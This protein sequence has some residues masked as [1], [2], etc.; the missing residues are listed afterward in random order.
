MSLV[1]RL[2]A[3]ADAFE[4]AYASD[5]WSKLDPYFTADAVYETVADAPFA[6]RAEGRDAVKAYFKEMVDNFDRRFASRRVDVIEGPTEQSG[7]VW[8][9]WAATYTLQDA[10]P[11][12]MEGEETAEFEGERIKRL[13]DR[14]PTAMTQQTVQYMAEHGTKLK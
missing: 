5:D 1:Q 8:F 6:N 10:P 7:K 2:M 13:E 4:A 11:L 12:R 14:M 9:R 3:Y